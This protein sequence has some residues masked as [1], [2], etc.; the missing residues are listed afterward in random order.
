MD[1]RGDV[2]LSM[3]QPAWSIMDPLVQSIL[4]G[5]SDGNGN[6]NGIKTRP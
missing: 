6:G 3:P 2:I 4:S 5:L 1:N